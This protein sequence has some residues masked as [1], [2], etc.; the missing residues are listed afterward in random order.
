[1]SESAKYRFK[2]LHFHF[3][4]FQYQTLIKVKITFC[5]HDTEF[6]D[7]R[8]KE[9]EMEAMILSA[10]KNLEVRII[11]YLQVKINNKYLLLF[12]FL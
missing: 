2:N 1:M 11:F 7:C 9:R 10:K 12:R 8:R 5:R 3:I 6:K 4:N